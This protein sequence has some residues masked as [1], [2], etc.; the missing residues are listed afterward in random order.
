MVI[1]YSLEDLQKQ[2]HD[3]EESKRAALRNTVRILQLGWRFV[4]LAGV[5]AAYQSRRITRPAGRA[6][7]AR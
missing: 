7:R 2:I 6:H 5:I 3:L 1:S 4:V